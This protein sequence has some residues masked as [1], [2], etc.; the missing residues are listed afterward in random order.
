MEVKIIKNTVGICGFA[1]LFA[2]ISACQNK[3]CDSGDTIEYRSMNISVTATGTTIGVGNMKTVDING[4]GTDDLEMTAFYSYFGGKSFKGINGT[5]LYVKA[6]T[7][8]FFNP[9]QL[10]SDTSAPA[11]DNTV[12]SNAT[13][14]GYIGFGLTL[15]DGI[16]YGWLKVSGKY[17][18]ALPFV[19]VTATLNN[20]AYSRTPG[21]SIPAGKF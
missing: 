20:A 8:V 6:D 3:D 7:D 18:E 13:E 17:A 2:G 19:S 15:P 11:I 21:S 16:H 12:Y 10:I 4:D 9:S 1:L 5:S 14:T